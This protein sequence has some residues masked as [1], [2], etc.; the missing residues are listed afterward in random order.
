MKRG[1]GLPGREL[2][3]YT[4]YTRVAKCPT[5][6]RGYIF[7]FFI[8]LKLFKTTLPIST[9]Q[10]IKN[11]VHLHMATLLGAQTEDKQIDG[12]TPAFYW[13]WANNSFHVG[14]LADATTTTTD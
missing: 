12:R 7:I 13:A 14:W 3:H 9:P 11:T 4:W 6:A 1:C 10:S 2:P 5:Y 8:Y